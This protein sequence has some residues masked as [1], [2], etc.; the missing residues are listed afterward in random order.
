MRTLGVVTVG[1]TDWSLWRPIL[2]ELR[3]Y[4][5]VQVR[6]YVTSMHL[7]PEFGYTVRDI[8]ADGFVVDEKVELL[9]SSDSPGGVAMAMG[10]GNLGFA[11]VFTRSRPDMLLVLGD[12]FETLSAVTA[13]MPFTIPVV[14]LYGGEATEANTDEMTRHAITKL[15]HLHFT[16]TRQ[17]ADR[18]CRGL[19]EEPWRVLHVGATSIDEIKRTETLSRESLASRN[20]LDPAAPFL[21]STFHP[22]TLDVEHTDEHVG[23]LLDALD[24]FGMQVMFTYPNADVSGRR[25][26]E[27]L[28][29]YQETHPGTALVP[30]LGRVGY[31]SA[32]THAAAMVGNSSSGIVEAASYRLPVVNIGDRQKG[33]VRGLNVI[34]VGSGTDEILRGLRMSQAQEFRQSLEDLQNPYGDGEAS[35][36]IVRAIRAVRLDKRLLT[37]VLQYDAD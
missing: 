25:I 6:L 17:Y 12:R 26:L 7:S 32:L 31:Y 21:L 15:S 11:Q 20:G 28:K 5:D 10:L 24:R 37:K 4:S 27:L 19:G 2:D 30:S 16:S 35:A 22:V 9:M 23:A 18:I 13:A 34:D 8:E 29:R 1:R 36:K 14:H 3:K 33:R